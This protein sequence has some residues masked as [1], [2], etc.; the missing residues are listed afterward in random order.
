MACPFFDPAARIEGDWGGPGRYPLGALYSGV[1]R[2]RPSHP[3]APDLGTLREYC[4]FGYAR[5]RCEG[6]PPDSGPDAVRFGIAG[7][8]GGLVR[9]HYVAERD[10]H[11]FAYT[12]LEYDTAA[13]ALLTPAEQEITRNQAGVYLEHYLSRKRRG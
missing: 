1:C 13:N 4:N 6:F 7:D 2:A 9:I 3:V 5:G 8:N 12:L 11:P 10:H